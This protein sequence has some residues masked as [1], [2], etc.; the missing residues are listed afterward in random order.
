MKILPSAYIAF[1]VLAL[2]SVTAYAVDLPHIF[3]AN[4]PAVAEDVNDNFT[5]LQDGINGI[6]DSIS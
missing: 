6:I 3:T 5:A 2:F 1:F 4:T